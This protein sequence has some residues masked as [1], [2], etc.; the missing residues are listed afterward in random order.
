[1]PDHEALEALTSSMGARVLFI[2]T[3][4]PA[5][6]A[7]GGA[8][9]VDSKLIRHLQRFASVDVLAVC[10]ASRVPHLPLSVR[11]DRAAGLGTGVRMILSREPYQVAKFTFARESWRRLV[12]DLRR[13]SEQYDSIVTSQ[14]PALLVSTRTG[15]TVTA[16]VAHNVD[17]VLARTYSPLALRLIGDPARL[18]KAEKSA[19]GLPRSIYALSATDAN[20]LA[21]W[22]LNA[23]HL[24][25]P[26]ER[27][28]ASGDAT[29][30]RR[31]TIGF[32]GKFD[33][34]PNVKAA[35]VLVDVVM[36][37]LSER[38]GAATPALVLAG[39]GSE[40]FAKEGNIR[41]LGRVESLDDFYSQVDVV[42]IPRFGAHESGVSVKMLEAIERGKRVIATRALATDAGVEEYVELADTVL[43]TV[44]AI[45]RLVEAGTQ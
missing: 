33:W 7:K 44:D 31:L 45:K 16:H 5:D 41:T 35:G 4:S 36:P 1:M 15:L 26:I 32:L 38:L 2:T 10:D 43:E 29:I 37:A 21:A 34:P 14:W 17:S 30:E 8:A 22:G 27:S 3:Y 25:L 28:H 42:V 40:S 20:R 19:L 6:A 9:W 11:G 24:A 18:E 39:Q 23:S 13:Q 12:E